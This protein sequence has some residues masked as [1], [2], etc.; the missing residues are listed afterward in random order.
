MMWALE[1][2]NLL[3]GDEVP[4]RGTEMHH[5]FRDDV[6]HFFVNYD[7]DLVKVVPSEPMETLTES[8]LLRG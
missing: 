2:V 5:E 1:Y 6:L 8:H 3:N 7:I 4:L